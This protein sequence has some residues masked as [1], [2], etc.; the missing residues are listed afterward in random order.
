MLA[1]IEAARK[2]RLWAIFVGLFQSLNKITV[3]QMPALVKMVIFKRQTIVLL[4]FLSNLML[5]LWL[6]RDSKTFFAFLQYH[7]N[8]L[9]EAG[10]V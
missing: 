6:I 4:A 9:N 5:I 2:L 8:Q 1:A 10:I 7:Q 3:N